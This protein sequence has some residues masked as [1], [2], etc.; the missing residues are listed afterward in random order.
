MSIKRTITTIFM[1]PT[2]KIPKDALKNNGFINGYIRDNL[3]DEEYLDSIYLLF[4][5]KNLN[6]FRGFL[7]SEYER[8]AQVIDDYDYP[9]G[10]VVV[11][12]KLDTQF[13]EDFELIKQSKYSK[14]SPDFQNL[15]PKVVKIVKNNVS[16]DEI[17][18]QYKIFNR[19]E[20]LITFWEEKFEVKF[21]PEQ[22]VWRRF[23]E[24]DECINSNVVKEVLNNHSY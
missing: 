6:L 19:T 20:D 18:L 7:D 13:K 10:F 11:V 21:D 23:I 4:Q 5:P 24:E 15:F 14:T 17:S 16:K 22:E 9:N 3:K 12:Y 8:T 1:V 2:L